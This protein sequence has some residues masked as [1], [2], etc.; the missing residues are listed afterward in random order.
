MSVPTQVRK[1]HSCFRG[2]HI[3]ADIWEEQGTPLCAGGE[4]RDLGASRTI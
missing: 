1:L 3:A 4:E 2:S